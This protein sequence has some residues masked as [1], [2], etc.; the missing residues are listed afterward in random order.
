M[1]LKTRNN[2]IK[3]FF[4]SSL[5][6][7]ICLITLFIVAQIR[8]SI[9]N[10][11]D[12]R[13]PHFI[14]YIP[15]LKNNFIAVEISFG[16]LFLYIPICFYVLI[17]YFENTQTSEII[18][19]TGFLIACM[20]E[21]ARFITICLGLW[22]SFTNALIFT[23][24]IVLFGRTLAPLSFLCAAILSEGSQKQD[25]ERNY[26]IMLTG[27]IVFAALVPVNTARI[28]STGLVTE[29][30]MTLINF[31]RVSIVLTA[32][33]SFLVLGFKKNSREQKHLASSS[34]LL[35]LAYLMLISC[36]NFVYLVLGTAGLIAGTFRY[37]YFIHKMYMWN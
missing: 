1:T 36:D 5:I 17:R 27:S 11:P 2:F 22:Q 34:S 18:F 15:F 33:A 20:G 26:I 30:F 8:H 28:T 19:F 9:I 32:I 31:F 4:L 16:I 3:L 25:V 12:L 10:P 7:E 13:I 23:G 6:I 37:F 24:N 35:L 21:Y 14:N 29:G